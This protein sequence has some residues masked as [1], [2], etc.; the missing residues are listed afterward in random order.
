MKKLEQDTES[1]GVSVRLPAT[2]LEQIDRLASE[3]RR[4]RGN[5]VRI[6]LEDALKA[7]TQPSVK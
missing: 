3:E 7:R 6:L 1:V 2:L 4:T 5:V